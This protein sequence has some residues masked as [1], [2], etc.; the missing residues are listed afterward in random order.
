MVFTP[1]KGQ[2]FESL[3]QQHDE[4]NLFEDSLFPANDRSLYYTKRSPP[5]IIWKRPKVTSIYLIKYLRKKYQSFYFKEINPDAE[6]VV[7][8][9][10]RCDMDQGF[11]GNCWFIAGNYKV[12]RLDYYS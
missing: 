1:F 11:V 8:G 7:D 3:K 4:Y 10:N 12:S 5:G 6:F 2:D 9:F